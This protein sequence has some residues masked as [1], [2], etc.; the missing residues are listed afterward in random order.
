MR[1]IVRAYNLSSPPTRGG[2]A[3]PK[4]GPPTHAN[5]TSSHAHVRA[6][7][8]SPVDRCGS[9]RPCVCFYSQGT[10]PLDSTEAPQGTLEGC[11]VTCLTAMTRYDIL[12][13]HRA[14][15][16]TMRLRC[17]LSGLRHGLCMI[18]TRIFKLTPQTDPTLTELYSEGR[19]RTPFD[20]RT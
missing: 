5:V 6:P 13:V 11:C 16:G 7:I 3:L 9:F 1:A 18:D 17:G 19:I 20:T 15:S 2:L 14:L 12:T 8:L 10:G 4:S